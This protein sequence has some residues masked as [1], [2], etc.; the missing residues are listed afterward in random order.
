MASSAIDI[1][2]RTP[3][4]RSKPGHVPGSRAPNTASWAPN[5]RCCTA[6]NSDANRHFPRIR[7]LHTSNPGRTCARF[8]ETPATG[9]W[10]AGRAHGAARCAARI[11]PMEQL[12]DVTGTAGGAEGHRT[13]GWSAPPATG[14]AARGHGRCCRKPDVDQRVGEA[15]APAGTAPGSAPASEPVARRSALRQGSRGRRAARYPAPIPEPLGHALHTS[16]KPVERRS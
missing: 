16:S 12:G 10:N 9:P 3:P 13:R 8:R 1:I 5:S 15:G 4:R 7:P 11:W 14:V 6:A 2:D